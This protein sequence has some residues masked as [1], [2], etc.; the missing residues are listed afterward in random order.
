MSTDNELAA[1]EQDGWHALSS[2]STDASRFYADVLDA[3]VRML[4]PGGLVLTDRQE[5]IDM[6]RGQP[7]ASH[8]IE[9][10]DVL[11]PNLGTGIVTYHVAVQRASAPMYN[12]LKTPF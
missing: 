6:M 3:E 8:A 4:L 1:L 2:N 11:E 10:I 5:I 9:N 12:A 7:W